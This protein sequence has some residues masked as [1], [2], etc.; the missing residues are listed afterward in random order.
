MILNDI[1][2]RSGLS[3]RPAVFFLAAVVFVTGLLAGCGSANKQI[4]T[5]RDPKELYDTAMKAFVDEKYDEAET[6]F[7]TLV[8]EYPVS[9]YSL[10]AQLMLGDVCFAQEKYDE[11]GSYYTNFVA[12]HPTHG[13]AAYALFQKGMSHFKDVLSVDR[14]QTSTRKALFA[15]EDLVASYPGS[16]YHEK[17]VEL[18]AFLKKRLAEREF[19]IGRF[20][21]KGKNYKGALA[22]FR[23]VL[24][25]FPE[26][27]LTEQTLYYIGESYRR[28]GEDELAKDAFM[29]LITN[30]PDSPFVKDARAGLSGS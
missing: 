20:Y 16:P 4:E 21:F 24:S 19:Y 17:A 8:E 15:F 13:R 1:L 22:R 28:L 23:D 25:R 7:K 29:T 10:E 12:L 6:T 27:G 3:L 26:V 11:S 30:Y 14:D 9:P 18:I 5:R 2:T